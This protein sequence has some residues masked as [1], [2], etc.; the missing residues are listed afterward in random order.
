MSAF[1][2]SASVAVCFGHLS[3]PQII[4]HVDVIMQLAET[5]RAKGRPA[6]AAFVCDD[7]VRKQFARRAEKRDPNLDIGKEIQTVNKELLEQVQQRLE[8]VLTATGMNNSS[9]SSGSQANVADVA[10][11]AASKQLVAD[12]F[13]KG[14]A[15]FEAAGADSGADYGQ[16]SSY[17]Q[18]TGQRR[19]RQRRQRRTRRANSELAA[20]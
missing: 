1:L 16:G 18:R 20:E 9:S 10:D 19:I 11:S 13:H 7:L 4:S 2:Q 3:W 15:G 6:Y 8:S 5:Q 12:A 14:R 17:A